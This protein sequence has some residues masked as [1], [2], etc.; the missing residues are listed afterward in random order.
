V[1]QFFR[2][3]GAN[4]KLHTEATRDQFSAELDFEAALRQHKK[5]EQ[6]EIANK[7]RDDLASI[8]GELHGVAITPGLVDDT[9]HLWFVADGS[10]QPLQAFSLAHDPAQ[11]TLGKRVKA[12]CDFALEDAVAAE[13]K[14]E[15]LALLARWHYSSW[16][17]GTWIRFSPTRQLPYRR[18][19][20]AISRA[21]KPAASVE[22]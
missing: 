22:T 9:V 8:M 18:I 15:H 3:G 16:R 12:L 10:V 2:D 4:L 13:N 21:A 17:D 11:V 1:V 6:I 14:P 19:L 20:A 7:L 5:L